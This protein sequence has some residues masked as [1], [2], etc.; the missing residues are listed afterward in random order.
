MNRRHE[1][2]INQIREHGLLRA[3]RPLP[4]AGGKITVGGRTVLN[5]SSN[6]YLNLAGDER[7][8][9]G[10]TEAVRKYG[11]GATASRL[12]SGSLDLHS[13]LEQRLAQF[14]GHEAALVFGS[15][16]LANLGV[17]SALAGRGDHIFADKLSHASLLDGAALSKAGLHRY[18]HNDPNHLEV[19]LRRCDGSGRKLIVAESVFS[20][21]G[22]IAPVEEL[23]G[24]AKAFDAI[25]MIDEAHAVGVFGEGGSGLCR[26]CAKG[27]DIV[28]GTLSK[29]LGGYG[30]LAACNEA[31]REL[32]IN[33][34]RSFIYS[35][36]LPPACLGSALAAIEIIRQEPDLGRQLLKRAEHFRALL[37]QLGFDTLTSQ[38][39]IVPVLVGDNKKAMALS[40]ALFGDGV[41]AVAVRPPT[42]PAGTARLR[43][44]V[45]LAHEP[46]DLEV[47][48][49]ALGRCA[50]K[51]GLL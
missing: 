37:G 5:F 24:L 25:L 22:D 21:D 44:S 33:R 27:V 49:Q 8:K 48:A 28:I 20:M 19:L 41:L 11:C 47:A 4:A 1:T 3:L 18:R 45:T 2:E 23:A 46:D 6:D 7:L 50:K 42:V 10:A 34:A 15:G 9:A 12:M 35:T 40:E 43:F 17:L 38:S 13:L 26:A 29:S 31:T 14:L 36:A 51:V 32:L 16:Y 30:G 39:Q